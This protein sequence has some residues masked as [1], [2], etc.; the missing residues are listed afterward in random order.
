MR[1][2]RGKHLWQ[3]IKV[4]HFKLFVKESKLKVHCLP[5]LPFILISPDLFPGNICCSLVAPKRP[6]NTWN[7]V[8]TLGILLCW[9]L[10]LCCSPAQETMK[11]A[12]RKP[13]IPQW[14]IKLCR[15]IY[16]ERCS[17]SHVGGVRLYC[18]LN[19]IN[20][21]PPADVNWVFPQ[22]YGA[23]SREMLSKH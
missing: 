20:G 13:H 18:A 15:Y 11:P 22:G 14:I 7:P 1:G 9:L 10:P 12:E 2:Q 5:E 23:I 17:D 6:S 21:H 16:L 8:I 3:V 4:Y 19:S